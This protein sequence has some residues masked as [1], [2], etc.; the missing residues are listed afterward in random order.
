M[1]YFTRFNLMEFWLT[2]MCL[3]LV[4]LVGVAA[5]LQWPLAYRLR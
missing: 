5:R 1:M 2:Y 3:K 4:C